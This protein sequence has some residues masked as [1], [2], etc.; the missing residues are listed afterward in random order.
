MKVSS[1]INL[2]GSVETEMHTCDCNLLAILR[3][4]PFSIDKALE[5][6]QGGILEPK[7]PKVLNLSA[8]RFLGMDHRPRKLGC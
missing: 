3:I 4:D 7:L 8:S 2:Q 6:N 5:F 1:S